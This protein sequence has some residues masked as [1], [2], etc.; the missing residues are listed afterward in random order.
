MND[1]LA[2]RFEGFEGTRSPCLPSSSGEVYCI[3][4]ALLCVLI[5]SLCGCAWL[6]EDPNYR[7]V[8]DHFGITHQEM[9]AFGKQA[10]KQHGKTYAWVELKDA[11]TI[12]IHTQSS[13]GIEYRRVNGQWEYINTVQILTVY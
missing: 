9:L 8:A 2:A 13:D 4:R 12:L 10:C 7:A 3:M 1:A 6:T 11:E 5:L